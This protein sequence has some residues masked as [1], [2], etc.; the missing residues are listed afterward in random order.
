MAALAKSMY[1]LAAGDKV[2]QYF[3]GLILPAR[4]LQIGIRWRNY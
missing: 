4:A 1:F 3:D 2:I